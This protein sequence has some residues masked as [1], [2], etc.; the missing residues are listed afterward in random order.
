MAGRRALCRVRVVSGGGGVVSPWIVMPLT[1]VCM[2]MV[3]LYQGRLA[4]AEMPRWRRRLRRVNG[5][6]M[7]LALPAVG[8]GFSLV[9][10]S[11]HPGWFVGVWVVGLALVAVAVALAGLD[12]GA[13]AMLGREARAAM[14]EAMHN[15]GHEPHAGHDARDGGGPERAGERARPR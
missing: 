12:L 14:R 13:T 8:A 2:A 7:L 3:I 4:H 9:N 1:L 5:W 6:V 11:S 10:A 15:Q